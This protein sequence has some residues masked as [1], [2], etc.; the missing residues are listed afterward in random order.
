LAA[1][2]TSPSTAINTV[3]RSQKEL[4]ATAKTKQAY[5]T[6]NIVEF[7][8]TRVDYQY[9]DNT[10]AGRKLS[11]RHAVIGH[12]KHYTKG[13]LAGRVLWCPPHMRGPDVGDQVQRQYVVEQTA[14]DMQ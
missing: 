4:K 12:F 9:D 8:K 5:R 3:N 2:L 7:D 13:A 1:F 10:P 11:V 6:I 14:A